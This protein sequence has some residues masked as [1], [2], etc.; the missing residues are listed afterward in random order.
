[1]SALDG[2]LGYSRASAARC[3]RFRVRAAGLTNCLELALVNRQ[4]HEMDTLDFWQM[5][6][7]IVTVFGL[8]SPYLTFVLEQRK[9]RDN[10]DEEV[11]QLLSESYIDF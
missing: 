2:Q 8:P 1:M 3:D 7:N 9:E 4:V 5:S 11:Y 10:E 6:A